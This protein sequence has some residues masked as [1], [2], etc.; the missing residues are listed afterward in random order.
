MFCGGLM[1]EGFQCTSMSDYKRPPISEETK[2]L[3]DEK[4]PDGVSYDF[5]L[6]V[7]LKRAPASDSEIFQ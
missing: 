2:A 3:L 6:R 7:L 4:K 5:Y 1:A